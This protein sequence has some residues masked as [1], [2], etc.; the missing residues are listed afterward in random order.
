MKRTFLKVFVTAL[1]LCLVAGTAV[2]ASAEIPFESYTKW[3]D[4]GSERKEVYNRPMYEPQRTVDAAALGVAKFT[5]LNNICTDKDGNIYILDSTS[6]IVITDKSFKLIR[7]IGAINEKETYDEASSLYV[8]SDGTLYICDTEQHRVLHITSK[9][10]LIEIITLPDSPL[11]PDGFDF[12]PTSMV[13]DSYGYMYILSDGSYYGAL[14]YAPDK[15]F[16]GFYGANTVSA[17]IGSVFT[18]IKNRIMPNNVKKGNTAQQLPYCFVDINIDSD[19]F[20][21][22]CNG[23]TSKWQ[24]NGQ[25]RKLSPGSGSNILKSA[26]VNFVEDGINS[27]YSGGAV[28]KQDIIEIAVDSRGFIY[29]L[30]SAYGRIYMYDGECRTLTAFGGGMGVGTQTGTFVTVSGI[31]L[32]DDGNSVLV[33]DSTTNYI[34]VFGIT[35][36]GAKAKDLLYLANNGNYDEAKEGFTE[37]LKQDENFQP[38]YSALARAYL[39]EGDYKTAMEYSKIG[40]DRET[41]ALA[42]E[43]QRKDFINN[44][45]T[46]IFAGIVVLIAGAVTFI[47]ISMKKKLVLIKNK[48]LSLMFGSML[49]PANIFTDIK[50][51]G[52]GSV[53]LCL[54]TL[55]IYYITTVLQTLKGGFLFSNYDPA[56]F[57]SIL[58][59][60]RS[61]GLVVLWIVANW[62]VCT[63]L[64]GKGKLKEIT[65]ITC[66]SLWPI[67]IEKL[68]RLVLTNVL[69]PAEA[70]F[71]N[72]FDSIALIY[73]FIML[74]IGML[75]IHDF[76]MGRFIGTSVLTVVGMAAIVFLFIMVF[77]LIQ[78]FNGFVVTIVTE[79]F[80]L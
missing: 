53:P 77:M 59:L 58:V 56:S 17:S 1:I 30:E 71:L 25:I 24:R 20:I 72:I 54:V 21:Y 6:R 64:G 7:E 68:I 42:Y 9:G 75:K 67:I 66:Y 15:S 29:G 33:C 41:Y 36:Y 48:E 13:V 55:V 4:V 18:N 61:I 44:N 2:T 65:V 5:K 23:F 79:L 69:L 27:S 34:T 37:L 76:S 10:A 78:Q 14:L 80:T 32:I 70:G 74:V 35:D 46:L 51:K 60:V 50:E 12:R 43:Y 3:T 16:L 52:L 31:A 62:L 19:G 28:S 49:H 8:H 45:F 40:Y 11:I 57:N 38:A 73:F 22:T 47:V 26:S 39:N 63:L